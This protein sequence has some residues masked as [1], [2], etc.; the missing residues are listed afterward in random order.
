MSDCWINIRIAWW[1]IQA[2]RG[3]LWKWRVSSNGF[4]R[5]RGRW[6]RE[7]FGFYEFDLAGGW[8]ARNDGVP[9]AVNTKA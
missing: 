9:V 1:H 7:V 8:R 4:W 5:T 2:L 3:S 6:K